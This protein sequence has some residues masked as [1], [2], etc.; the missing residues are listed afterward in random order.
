MGVEGG[1]GGSC[2]Y[3]FISCLGTNPAGFTVWGAKKDFLDSTQAK[4]IIFWTT[5]SFLVST[6]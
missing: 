6:I 1:G 2:C 5:P 4:K 3:S